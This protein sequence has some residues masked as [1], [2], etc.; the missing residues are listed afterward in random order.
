ML[1]SMEILDSIF[2][3][4]FNSANNNGNDAKT[5]FAVS[6]Y[7]ALSANFINPVQITIPWE[8]LAGII[9]SPIVGWLIPFIADRRGENKRSKSLAEFMMKNIDDQLSKPNEDIVEYQ[10]RADELRDKIQ[11]MYTEGKISES[12]YEK[13]NNKVSQYQDKPI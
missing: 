13:L 7:G 10:K 1:I 11:N 4:L 2:G 8:L 12:S 3:S 6:K 9:L 5:A